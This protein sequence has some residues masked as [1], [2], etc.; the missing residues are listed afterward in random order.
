[1]AYEL[2]DTQLDLLVHLRHGIKTSL[3]LADSSHRSADSVRHSMRKLEDKEFVRRTYRT[4]VGREVVCW[5]LTELG[6]KQLP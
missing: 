1:M 2:A 3:Q 4:S 5:E 6:R